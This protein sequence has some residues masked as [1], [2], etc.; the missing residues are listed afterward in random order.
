[1]DIRR[2]ARALAAV[3]WGLAAGAAHAQTVSSFGQY[4]PAPSYSEAATTSQYLAM[5]D[6]VR[7]ALSITRPYKDGKPA[8][9][10][11]PVIWQ[12]ALS[13]A[14]A[15]PL[16]LRPKAGALPGYGAVP[17]LAYH[18]YVVVQVAR[19]GQGSSFGKR[20]G[21]NDRGE[22]YDAYEVIDWLA[23]Q[24][25]S[26]GAVGVYGC[27]NTG[28]ASMHAVTAANP[29]LKA[30]WAGC[31]SWEKYDG[32][33]RGGIFA[34][35]RTGP[36][37][38]LEQDMSGIPVQGDE[39]KA[40][41]RQAAQ[42]HQ[43]VGALA[44]M[45]VAMP[46]RDDYAP[47]VGSRFWYE[48]SV[49]GYLPQIKASGTAIYVQ[50]GWRDDLRAQGLLTYANMAGDR[51]IVIGPWGHCESDDFNLLA[52]MHRFFDQHLKGID[53][54]ILSQDPIHY[55]TVNAPA[56]SA[57]RSSKIWP[58]AG[59]QPTKFYLA[60]SAAAGGQLVSAPPRAREDG[61]TTFTVRYDIACPSS[62]S[63]PDGL[64]TGAP[65]CPA[66][67]GGPR[68]VTAPLDADT[69]VTGD[70]VADLWI[71]SSA[72]DQNIFVYMEDQAPD[73][74]VT[75]VTDARLKASLRKLS[76]PG[77]ENFGLPYQRSHKEDAQPL[78]SGEPTRLVF[79][80][81]P[82]SRIFK[83][84]HRIRISVAGSDYR[85]RDRTPVSPAPMVTIHD[86]VAHPSTISLPVIT[87]KVA[88]IETTQGKLPD[89]TEYRIDFPKQWNGTVLIG[90]DY[91]GHGDSLAG[92]TNAGTRKLLDQGFAMAGTTR[93]ITGWA[94]QL[95]VA[96]AVRTLDIFEAKYGKPKHAI[97]FGSSQGGHVAAVSV[98]AY[99]ARW[100]GA[101]VQCGGL[102]GAVGQWQGKLDA[103]FVAKTLLAPDSRLP[104][105]GIP[106]DFE[107]TALPAWHR[108]IASAQQTPQ[109][110]A[111]IALAATIAQLPG[112]SDRSKPRPEADDLEGRQTGLYGSLAVGVNLLNQAMSSRAQ[113]EALSGGNISSNAGVDYARLLQEVD[114]DGLIDKLYR[115]A[116]LD[117][118]LDLET[119]ARAP[120]I[121]A[122][123]KAI[124]YVA[125]GV[126]DGNLQVPVLTLSGIGDPIS[127]VSAQQD[128]EATVKAAGKEALLRQLYTA[129]TGHCGFTPA[130]SVAA[131]QMLL[132][133]LDSGEWDG[134]G[135][136]AMNRAAQQ[137]GLG[138][139]RFIDYAPARFV[140]RYSACDL[141][142]E[143]GAAG[144]KPMKTPGQTLPACL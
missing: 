49:A 73:G 60:G 111:R 45:W 24:P 14:P 126:F 26:T 77:Y 101:L 82:T 100:D 102:S 112:W 98:Q 31:F 74:T 110:R 69:E 95:A 55:F 39:D 5:R 44:E 103:L 119:L 63:R 51:H 105:I 125:S 35:W 129:S 93:K 81:L 61:S 65:P 88:A 135:A 59:T 32:F 71:S 38:T 90:L 109:G 123:P 143:L 46:Y 141:D 9:G 127:V 18:G 37:R 139:S 10:R 78:I 120:R 22:A 132:H 8:A 89:G 116:G 91:A 122:D 70:A 41:L 115:Q 21:Y 47:G 50:G 138:Q 144:V 36:T 94:I 107:T 68:F 86:A 131:V 128:Y 28:D 34:N 27:S 140:R 11:F 25:W 53:T 16:A 113:I 29:H 121:A 15:G 40:L 13:I 43:A 58:V 12:H 57:W 83:A 33:W 136:A 117:L 124:A 133:R 42:E 62:W 3:L 134:S 79:A 92:D 66:E 6:G 87:P 108:T 97:E 52:E 19:R 142:R 104:V 30:A 64:L 20:R 2:T 48:G 76:K 99:P 56:A 23:A 114:P 75:Q 7:L 85:E 1:M 80:F 130:E 72:S 54:G 118:R 96:N 4:Q 84:G 67:N 17:S 106:K 137:T